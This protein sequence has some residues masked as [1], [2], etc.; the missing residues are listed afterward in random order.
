MH[1]CPLFDP[2]GWCGW[3]GGPNLSL[4]RQGSSKNLPIP[5]RGADENSPRRSGNRDLV[6]QSI[7]CSYYAAILGNLLPRRNHTG[8]RCE[9][10]TGY[11]LHTLDRVSWGNLQLLV[12]TK[13]DS[14]FSAVSR[15][16][17]FSARVARLV[18]LRDE[19]DV[20]EFVIEIEY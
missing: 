17:G 19:F 10:L 5:I 2:F 6:R 7:P 20:F 15:P 4:I 11:V 1:C 9:L 8:Y 12:H 3:G 18:R 13:R 14:G 16:V